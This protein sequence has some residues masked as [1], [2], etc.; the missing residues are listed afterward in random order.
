MIEIA[1]IKMKK[2]G[3]IFLIKLEKFEKS[4]K[5]KERGAFEK[6]GGGFAPPLRGGGG[7]VVPWTP[8]LS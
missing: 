5:I 8:V 3:K 2:L 1:K 7:R 4:W 6:Q